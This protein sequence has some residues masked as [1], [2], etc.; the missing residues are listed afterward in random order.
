MNDAGDIAGTYFS[1][2]V[3]VTDFSGEGIPGTAYFLSSTGSLTQVEV[4][5][6]FPLATSA[7]GINPRGNV[8]GEYID[9]N[10]EHGFVAT[11]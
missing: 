2:P 5:G 7:L 8:I 3:N 4:P 10:G 11:K 6:A 1:S 9:A